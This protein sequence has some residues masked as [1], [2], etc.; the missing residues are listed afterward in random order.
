[1]RT[2][3]NWR[4]RWNRRRRRLYA[5]HRIAANTAMVAL[6]LL[7]IPAQETA[8]GWLMAG[9]P[10]GRAPIAGHLMVRPPEPGGIIRGTVRFKPE[11]PATGPAGIVA[12]LLAAGRRPQA[13]ETAT[14][15]GGRWSVPANALRRGW[16][17]SIEAQAGACHPTRAATTSVPFLTRARV[18]PL[19]AASCNATATADTST[20]IRG[21]RSGT[22]R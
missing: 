8:T 17:Y 4:T 14:T 1:M 16:T 20:T 3:R 13:V 7:G 10:A 5:R 12:R 6:I 11:R 21:S 22:T 2:E 18:P 9:A 19:T 15:P